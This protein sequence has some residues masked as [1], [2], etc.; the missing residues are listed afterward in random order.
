MG[1][2][3]VQRQECD[4]PFGAPLGGGGDEWA[5]GVDQTDGCRKQRCSGEAAG[6]LGKWEVGGGSAKK[7][8][9]KSAAI[10]D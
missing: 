2:K 4:R 9:W 8:F 6:D 10:R 3:A 1:S 5:A 7:M